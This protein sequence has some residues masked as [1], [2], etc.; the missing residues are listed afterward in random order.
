MATLRILALCVTAAMICA[1]LRSAH[2]QIASAAAIAAGVIAMTLCIPDIEAV[3]D[4]LRLL[5]AD[6]GNR[7][8][9][10]LLRVCGIAMIAEFA[11]DIC[12]DAGE[13]ALSGRIEVCVR[14]GLLAG[15]L[16]LL[17]EVMQRISDLLE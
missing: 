2:P 6:A 11:A 12:R 3:S 10:Y 9:T 13:R 16:P 1:F 15:A 14:I 4:A 17:T 8:H 5:S 7:D